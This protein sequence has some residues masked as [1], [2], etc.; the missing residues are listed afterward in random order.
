MQKASLLFCLL[1]SC[2]AINAITTDSIAIRSH[3]HKFKKDFGKIYPSAEEE[4]TRLAIFAANF[5]QAELMMAEQEII[6]AEFGVTKF[7]DLTAEEF[8]HS[9]KGYTPPEK[10]EEAP[11]HVS[12]LRTPAVAS[13]CS[14]TLCDWRD[15]NAITGVK[16]QGRCGSCWAFS[17]TEELETAWYLA[18]NQMPLLSEQQLV[19]CDKIDQGCNG[20]TPP[21]AYLSI[22]VTHGL[23]SEES[24]PY[25]SGGGD[26]AACHFNSSSI[27]A[28]L[29]NWTYAIE[30]CFALC[31]HQDESALQKA[32][33]LHGPASICL[34]AR[35]WQFYNKG[36]FTSTCANTLFDSDHCV[37]LIGYNAGVNST[38]P[39]WIVRN[40]W[41]TDW[42]ENGFIYVAIGSNLCGLANQPT[43]AQAGLL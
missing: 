43:F 35:P 3:F 26:N 33:A 15:V 1:V 6:K 22:K 37:Q 40:S 25:T 17:V 21:T 27:A 36:V 28:T 7:M 12:L 18:G 11:I 10:L 38:Q 32:I 29:A 9:W 31:Q 4:A 39:Y 19:S 8:S 41:G 42:G 5:K 24:Y 23:D 30:P 13:P 34:N 14:S 16:N 20:G 2:I